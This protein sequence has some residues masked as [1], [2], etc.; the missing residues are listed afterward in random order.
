MDLFDINFLQLLEL[1]AR[2]I[3][4]V[5]KKKRLIKNRAKLFIPRKK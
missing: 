4:D 1:L 3:F 2:E 5:K